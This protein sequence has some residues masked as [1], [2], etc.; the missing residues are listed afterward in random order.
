MSLTI[1]ITMIVSL[2]A[3]SAAQPVHAKNAVAEGA[4]IED[5]FGRALNE[6]GVELVDWQG[7]IA[8]PYVKLSVTPPADAVYPVTIDIKATGTS[9]LMMDRPS[10]LSATGAEKTLTFETA[11][12]RKYFLLE[13]HP[14]RIGGYGEIE[15]YTLELSVTDANGAVRSQNTP[16]RVL[17]QDDDKEPEMPLKFDYRF[18]TIQPYFND[19]AI[20]DASEQA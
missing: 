14:D 15:N 17:D 20:R 11:D 3:V 9:R 12:E 19:A 4:M 7:Y 6:Y 2:F 13:I 8:N 16:I 18:D 1:C 5:I 10:T